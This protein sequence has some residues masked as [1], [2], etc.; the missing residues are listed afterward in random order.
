MPECKKSIQ[1][2]ALFAF[3]HRV[4]AA[5]AWVDSV[6]LAQQRRP[7]KLAA[8]TTGLHLHGMGHALKDLRMDLGQFTAAGLGG[9]L[10]LAGRLEHIHG[11]K[12]IGNRAA[13]SQQTVVAQYEE[14]GLAHIGQ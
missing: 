14:V 5:V 9:N 1:K 2:D 8:K 12:R 3:G 4:S 11:Q 10:N 7:G 6:E 13:A